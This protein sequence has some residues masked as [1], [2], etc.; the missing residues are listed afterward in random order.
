MFDLCPVTAPGQT[1][2]A[3]KTGPALER[4][5]AVEALPT[6]R[7]LYSGHARLS[8]SINVVGFAMPR[9][10]SRWIPVGFHS[11]GVGHVWTLLYP[12]TGFVCAVKRTSTSRT[13][14]CVFGHVYDR[15]L[16]P[17]SGF[18]MYDFF[19]SYLHPSSYLSNEYIY[20]HLVNVRVHSKQ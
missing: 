10:F 15:F 19:S 1:H 7:D 3:H 8:R 6:T 12:C 18:W 2:K 5:G 13:Y 20:S 4:P 16:H 11:L 14:F 9:W 17:A